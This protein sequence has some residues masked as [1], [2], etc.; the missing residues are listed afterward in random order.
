MYND[1]T[2]PRAGG[3]PVSALVETTEV[4]SINPEWRHDLAWAAVGKLAQGTRVTPTL[5]QDVLAAI[6]NHLVELSPSAIAA[7]ALGAAY[8]RHAGIDG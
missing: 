4:R 2:P 5:K 1:V 8:G 7:F 6:A 3:F